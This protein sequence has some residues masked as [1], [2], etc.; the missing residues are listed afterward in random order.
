MPSWTP[1]LPSDRLPP[2]TA[3]AVRAGPLHV[4]LFRT[5]E[6]TLLALDNRCPHEGYPLVQGTLK[7]CVVTCSWHN[8]KFDGRTGACLIG[9]EDAVT[10]PVREVEGSIEVDLTPPPV[11][12]ARRMESLAAGLSARD[13]GR[14]SRD[15]VRLLADGATASQVAAF[16][17][18]WDARYGEYGPSHGLPV[19]ADI[20]RWTDA[21]AGLDA[22]LP[23]AQALDV[24]AESNLR[25][26]PRDRGAPLPAGPDAAAELRAAVEAEDVARAEGLVRG[27]IAAGADIETLEEAFYPLVA[28]HFL[29]FGHPLIY[30]VKLGGL[31]RRVPLDLDAVFGA[32]AAGITTGTRED[33]LP[34]WAGFRKRWA[35]VDVGALEARPRSGT[36]PRDALVALDPPAALAA[37]VESDAPV[38]QILDAL[39]HAA[40]VRLGRFD[41]SID[42]RVGVQDDWLDITHR[43][44]VANAV[45]HAV[46]RWRSPERWRLI[47]M[48]AHFV[49]RARPYDGAPAEGFGG[50]ADPVRLREA[51]VRRVSPEAVGHAQALLDAGRAAE[52]AA[53][54]DALCLADT[55]VRGIVVAHLIKTWAAAWEEYQGTGDATP[56]LATV[57]FFAS[58][59]VERRYT[60]RVAEAV[61]LVTEGRPPTRIVD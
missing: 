26:P 29:D 59:V 45:R 37:V 8:Y 28:D 34:A 55:A 21:S 47:A 51:I 46:T 57:R 49:A 14:I 7:G 52:L 9:D 5:T 12:F 1:L 20:L 30:L 16:G 35:E 10:F 56:V 11:D 44:T 36:L 41:V 40:A 54:M 60:R 23:L 38:D 53:V 13:T 42:S 6:G 4:A 3:R 33:L 48:A 22:A 27:M 58:P 61:R 15:V 24:S 50:V 43:F 25:R 17:V 19:L 32:L 18:A 39:V 2:G 31:A